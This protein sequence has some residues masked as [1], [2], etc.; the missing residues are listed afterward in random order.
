MSA[1]NTMPELYDE[2]QSEET[3]SQEEKIGRAHV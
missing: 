1:K 3:L 2:V